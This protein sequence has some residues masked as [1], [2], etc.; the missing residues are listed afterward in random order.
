MSYVI[1]DFGSFG[2]SILQKPPLW[3]FYVEGQNTNKQRA[4]CV[5]NLAEV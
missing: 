5:L 1:F 3:V 4:E 2:P